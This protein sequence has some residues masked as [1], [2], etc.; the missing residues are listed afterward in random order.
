LLPQQSTRPLRI[1]Q[2]KCSP[3]Q[4]VR[5]SN[6]TGLADM[7]NASGPASPASGAGTDASMPPSG[8]PASGNVMDIGKHADVAM[9]HE[10]PGKQALVVGMQSETHSLLTQVSPS[11]Q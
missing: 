5:A 3:T 9:L 7:Q 8:R 11:S 2:A 6:A 10:V 4:I 1:A